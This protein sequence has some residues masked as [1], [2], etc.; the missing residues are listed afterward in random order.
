MQWIPEVT[1]PNPVVME[2]IDNIT[3]IP[4]ERWELNCCV[5]KQKVRTRHHH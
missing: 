3:N 4:K 2:P 1:C 5:C